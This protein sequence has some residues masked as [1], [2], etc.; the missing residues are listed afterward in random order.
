[1]INSLRHLALLAFAALCLGTLSAQTPP[2]EKSKTPA[3]KTEPGKFDLRASFTTPPELIQMAKRL[4]LAQ[5][6]YQ[7]GV[8]APDEVTEL[9][10]QLESI[11]RRAPVLFALESPGGPLSAFVAATSTIDRYSSTLSFTLINAGE[12]ADLETPLPPFALSNANWGTIIGVLDSF[13]ATRGLSLK[14]VGGN[15]ANPAEARSVVCVLR[16]LEPTADAKRAGRPELDSFQIGDNIFK[17]QTVEVIVDAIRSAW[18]LEPTND[19]AALRI[20]F[21]PATKLLLV[22]GPAPA[23]HIARQ[24]ILGLRKKPAPIL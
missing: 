18:E 23:T 11:E 10:Y 20:K 21:H 12:P 4:E 13:L 22:S 5:Q 7:Q 24:V 1:M 6:R 19:P 3:P 9:K 8:G 17:D 16:R 2:A 14:F 15:I